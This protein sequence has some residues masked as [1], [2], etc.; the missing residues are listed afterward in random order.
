MLDKT[1]YEEIEALELLVG[2][3]DNYL[4][5]QYSDGDCFEAIDEGH[6]ILTAV[7]DV[8]KVVCAGPPPEARTAGFLDSFSVMEPQAPT[9]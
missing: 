9:D 4:G 8:E 1:P 2:E 3:L 6:A 5:K 7:K